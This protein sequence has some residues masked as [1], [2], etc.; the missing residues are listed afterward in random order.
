MENRPLGRFFYVPSLVLKLQSGIEPSQDGF[1]VSESG[2]PFV[3][4]IANLL[5]LN[6]YKFHQNGL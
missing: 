2:L 3:A 4:Y 1:G 6:D 5:I